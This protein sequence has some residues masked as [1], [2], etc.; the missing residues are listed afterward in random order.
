MKYIVYKT[1]NLVNKYIYIG[2]HKTENPEIFDGYIGNGCYIN[3][4]SDW[5]NPKTAFQVALK[6]FG[7]KNFRRETISIHE[8]EE[9][10]YLTEALIVNEEFLSR[11]DVYNMVLG[12]TYSNSEIVKCYQYDSNGNYLRGFDSMADAALHL[13]ITVKAVSRSIIFK[14]KCKNYY[15][16]TNKVNKLDISQYTISQESV[17]VYRYLV[18]SGSF[19]KEY[20]SYSQASIDTGCTLIEVVRSAKLCYRVGKYQF[21]LIKEDSYDKAKSIYLRI[22]EVNKYDINGIFIKHYNSQKEAELENPGS[23]ITNSIKNK[24]PCK[25]NYF[26]SLEELPKFCSTRTNK[27]EVGMFDLNNNL[28]KTW[29]SVKSWKQEFP[30]NSDYIRVPKVYKKQYIFKFI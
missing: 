18:E 26:W 29:D 3:H 15:L 16:S 20:D 11:P 17:K 5:N 8:T 24:K 19:D 6:E 4:P 1:T 14:N 28:I 21:L 10:A 13:N 22:R 12:G 9:E 30:I 23:N 2:V 7:I 25:N 27:K